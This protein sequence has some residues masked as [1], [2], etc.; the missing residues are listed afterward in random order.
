MFETIHQ[1]E[2]RRT[3]HDRSTRELHGVAP[4]CSNCGKEP[5]VD[6]RGQCSQCLEDSTEGY[7]G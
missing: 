2:A 7:E 3:D 6:D 5:A 1:G 4:P